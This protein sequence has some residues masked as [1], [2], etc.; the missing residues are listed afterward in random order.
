[1]NKTESTTKRMKEF[2]KWLLSLSPDFIS[3]SEI[4]DGTRRIFDLSY[5]SIHV[6]ADGRWHH[7]TGSASD[8]LSKYVGDSLKV[9]HD[10]QAGV[11]E[12]AEEQS[13]GVRYSTI[14]GASGPIA[15][16]AVRSD[17]LSMDTIDTIASMIG[18]LLQ[19]ILRDRTVT[20][21]SL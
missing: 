6:C 20:A 13:L 3:L 16:L 10:H 12:L 14:Q 15:V 17:S 8:S 1:M 5:C 19:E 2:S 7:Y 11:V 18:M 21:A 4:A 9:T